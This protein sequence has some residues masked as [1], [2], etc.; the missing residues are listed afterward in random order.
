MERSRS[1][2]NPLSS[3]QVTDREL[4]AAV[5]RLRQSNYAIYDWIPLTPL[6]GTWVNFES[7][8]Q[9]AGYW[10]DSAGIV[11]LRGVVKL[12]TIPGDLATLPE[13][14]RPG[15]LVRYP[16]Y[17]NSGLGYVSIA[18]TGVIRVESGSNPQIDLSAVS[19][20]AEV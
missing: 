8:E 17:T 10:R 7:G 5:D 20:R 18:P 3:L 11:H 12:G 1:K 19:F 6:L 9:V 13:N 14:F 15:S 4:A 16:A 2:Q